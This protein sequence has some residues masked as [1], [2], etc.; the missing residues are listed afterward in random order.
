MTPELGDY[1]TPDLRII[2]VDADGDTVYDSQDPDATDLGRDFWSRPEVAEALTGVRATGTRFSVTLDQELQYV[3]VPVASGGIVHG[4]VRITYPTEALRAQVRR[5]SLLFGLT[6][7]AV[8]V[9]VVPVGIAVARWVT[10]PTRA[11]T[12][13]V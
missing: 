10:R 13:R 9:A 1:A 12:E 11:L 5:T 8:L 3:A 6:G 7:L 2:I 4:A